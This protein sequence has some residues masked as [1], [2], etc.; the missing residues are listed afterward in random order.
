LRSPEKLGLS[1]QA[2]F[3]VSST[4]SGQCWALTS[5]CTGAGPVRARREQWLQAR[6]LSALMV[7]DLTL[8][9]DAVVPL[10]RDAAR[11]HAQE[12]YK[13]FDAGKWQGWISPDHPACRGLA[14]NERPSS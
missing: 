9:Q 14:Q 5:Y 2:L 12:I 10:V 4:S 1:S 8:A 13:A 3:D 6:L 7:K 11:K